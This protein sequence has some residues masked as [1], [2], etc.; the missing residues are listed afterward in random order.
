M[1]TRGLADPAKRRDLF[2]RVREQKVQICCLQ[3]THIDAKFIK[4]VKAEWGLNAIICPYTSNAR[5]VAILFNTGFEYKINNVDLDQGGNY[6]IIDISITD[7]A[8]FTLV[9]LYGPNED[10]PDFYKKIFKKIEDFG[11]ENYMIC[12]DWNLVLDGEKDLFNYKTIN[13]PKARNLILS[14][15]AEKELVDIWRTFHETDQHYTWSKKNPIKMA[16]LDFFLATEYILPFV[17]NSCILPKY[18]SDHA[19]VN[20]T[21]NISSEDR[22][23]GYW[24]FNNSLLKDHDFIKLV[25]NEITHVKSIY[26]ATPYNPDYLK[27]C[28]NKD[29]QLLINDQ[30]FWETLLVQLRGRII[31]YASLKKRKSNEI[32]KNLN[33]TYPC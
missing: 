17:S 22:G 15:I 24:K 16:R 4:R 10:N 3:D 33:E 25:K 20:V 23:R 29:L 5:G 31:T 11:N 30:L 8:Q 12:G 13:N 26:A 32:E 9:N 1:N 21:I 2:K 18:K 14:Y 28:P 19:P 27:F 6:I 7:F